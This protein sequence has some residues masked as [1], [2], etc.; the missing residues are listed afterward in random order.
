MVTLAKFPKCAN[1]SLPQRIRRPVDPTHSFRKTA[2]T[3]IDDEGPSTRI[4]GEH[5][6]GD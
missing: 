1:Y 4:G 5:E 6:H 3:L 2:A